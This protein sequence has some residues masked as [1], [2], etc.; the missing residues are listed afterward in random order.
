MFHGP[1]EEC[2]R[3]R[4][5]SPNENSI[6]NLCYTDYRDGTPDDLKP[7]YT[8][9]R[10]NKEMLSYPELFEKELFIN[11]SRIKLGPGLSR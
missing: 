2:V 5:K 8:G 10:G 3:N 6:R 1:Q 9:C 7:K 11:K 4:R